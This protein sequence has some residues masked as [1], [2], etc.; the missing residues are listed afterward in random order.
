M[1]SRE[2]SHLAK[3]H[4][5]PKRAVTS[6]IAT[7]DR[8]LRVVGVTGTMRSLSIRHYYYVISRLHRSPLERYT[9]RGLTYRAD[10]R[11]KCRDSLSLSLARA[12]K[13]ERL[14]TEEI[15]IYCL[16]RAHDRFVHCSFISYR[17]K[18]ERERESTMCAFDA[19]YY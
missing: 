5:A 18:R 14:V 15:I 11:A 4:C 8:V 3:D 17:E 13:S 10:K 16:S 6:Y 12:R 1:L 2:E 19:P 9:S 7:R